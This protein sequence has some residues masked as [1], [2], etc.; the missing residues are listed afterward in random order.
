MNQSE[1]TIYFITIA[2]GGRFILGHY[3]IYIYIYIRRRNTLIIDLWCAMIYI[4]GHTSAV[5]QE[6]VKQ[7][8]TLSFGYPKR[9]AITFAVG[10]CSANRKPTN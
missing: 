9:H 5:F 6:K 2:R 10:K 7:L 1:V 8:S 4:E 3:R